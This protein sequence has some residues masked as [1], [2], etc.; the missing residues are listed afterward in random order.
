MNMDH[1]RQ[2][3]KYSTRF[4]F[5]KIHIIFNATTQAR[6][7]HNILLYFSSGGKKCVYIC[8][9]LCLLFYMSFLPVTLIDSD[10]TNMHLEC[11]VF[12]K[13]NLGLQAFL[14]SLRI[15]FDFESNRIFSR[16]LHV[17]CRMMLPTHCLTWNLILLMMCPLTPENELIMT[18]AS[19]TSNLIRWHNT[20]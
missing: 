1:Y 12:L 19:C 11:C 17:I 9:H 13:L 4:V 6:C 14:V 8:E 20:Q 15:G 5:K 16:F 2:I 18:K 10:H 3:W 7:L